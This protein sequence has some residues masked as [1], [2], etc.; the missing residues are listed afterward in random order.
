MTYHIGPDDYQ[1]IQIIEVPCAQCTIPVILGIPGL[2]DPKLIIY[3]ML[4]K[5]LLL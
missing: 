3:I 5:Q 1:C 2:P 4:I